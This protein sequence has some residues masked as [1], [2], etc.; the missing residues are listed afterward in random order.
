MTPERWRAIEE[1]F[2]RGRPPQEQAAALANVEPGLRQEVE[3]LL[4][5]DGLS[6]PEVANAVKEGRLLKTSSLPR[7]RLKSDIIASS[8]RLGRAAWVSYTPLKT[9]VSA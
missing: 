8:R 2:N 6:S 4:A 5:S 9:R 7:C 3:K 1:L